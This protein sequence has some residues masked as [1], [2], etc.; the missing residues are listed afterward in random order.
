MLVTSDIPYRPVLSPVPTNIISDLDDGIE[1]TLSR[2]VGGA[3]L[4]GVIDLCLACVAIQGDLNRLEKL[5]N[6][7]LVK[8]NS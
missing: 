7:N 3:E 5:A 4:G 6:R 1:C 2:F 8:F